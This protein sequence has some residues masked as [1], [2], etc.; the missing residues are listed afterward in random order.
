MKGDLKAIDKI[1]SLSAQLFD[2][3]TATARE[4]SRCFTS[5]VTWGII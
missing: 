3:E 1:M 5:P 2:E 4:R